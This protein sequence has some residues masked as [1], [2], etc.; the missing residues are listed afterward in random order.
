VA[1]EALRAFLERAVEDQS[2]QLAIMTLDDTASHFKRAAAP[3]QTQAPFP[4][5]HLPL[6]GLSTCHSS[7][8]ICNN[9]TSSCSGH[10][11]CSKASKA[12]RTCYV[13][14]CGS[15]KTGSGKAVKTTYWAGESCERQ[16]ISR[17]AFYTNQYPDDLQRH[18]TFLLFAGTVITLL[19]LAVGSVS[20]LYSV[21]DQ[22]LPSTLLATAV[23]AKR[24]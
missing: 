14:S 15:T 3:Q 7:L 8:D 21:G 13:C 16:D 11:K 17:Y 20:L 4:L 9:S 10:G 24:D 6:S 2:V 12:G 19:I 22:S 5:P 23:P 1:S 18:S